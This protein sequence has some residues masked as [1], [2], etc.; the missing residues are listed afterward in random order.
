MITINKA[1]II[2]DDIEF[3]LSTVTQQRDITGNGIVE[4]VE[5]DQVNAS[6]IPTTDG[7]VQTDISA[8]YT[9]TEID[10]DFAA[11][12]DVLVKT[13]LT[14][15]TPT[16]DYH[17]ATKKYVDDQTIAAGAG[18]MTKSVYDTGNNGVVDDSEKLDGNAPSTVCIA[19]TTVTDCD[20]LTEAGTYNGT[21]VTNSPVT[22][23]IILHNIFSASV[24]AQILIRLTDST[25]YFRV[26]DGTWQDWES[27]ALVSNIV[28]SLDGSADNTTMLGAEQGKILNEAKYNKVS[29]QT[30]DNLPSFNAIG[31]LDDSGISKTDIK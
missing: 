6:H 10:E 20:G 15:Y 3:G 19:R 29:G 8:R 11:K 2:K 18:D 7:F 27:D 31:Q 28:N 14:P 13:E 5:Y 23:A 1:K 25:S 17:P 22:G 4:D 16:N 26:Y 21:D 9:K 24:K 12:V 30:T